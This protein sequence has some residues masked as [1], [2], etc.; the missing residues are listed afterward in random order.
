VVNL[1]PAISML[2]N[3]LPAVVNAASSASGPVSPGEIVSIYGTSIGPAAPA[4][5]TITAGTLSTSI[6][7]VTVTFSGYPAPL[8]YASS[9]Q[10]NAIVPYALAGNKQPFVEVTF[11]GQK[12]N[13]PTLQLAAVA[14][15][16]FTANGQG[17]GP[18]AILNWDLSANSQSNPAT[19]G[20]PIVIYLTGEGLT[21][22]AQATGTITPVNTSGTGTLT[23]VP[24]LPVSVLIGGQPAAVDWY[25]EAPDLVAG[26]LQVNATVP[27]TAAGGLNSVSVQIGSVVAAGNANGGVTVWVK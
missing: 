4:Y 1:T 17:F 12:S 7:G 15:G 9:T 20:T 21:T 11:N 27:A 25:G 10:I 18:G 23:P 16:I 6:G 13:E 14:P 3:G 8:T 24:Q 22:P 2:P 26:V 5:A 19:R